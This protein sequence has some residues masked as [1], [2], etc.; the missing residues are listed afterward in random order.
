MQ[1]KDQWDIQDTNED[2]SVEDQGQKQGFQR[3]E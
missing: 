1:E 3:Y 2:Q